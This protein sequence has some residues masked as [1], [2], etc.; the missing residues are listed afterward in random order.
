MTTESESGDYRRFLPL[1]FFFNFY[2]RMNFITQSEPVDY[3]R[4]TIFMLQLEPDGYRQLMHL[5]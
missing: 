5:I 3:R 2:F 1:F 4:L